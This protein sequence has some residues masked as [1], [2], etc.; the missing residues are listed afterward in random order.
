ML[1]Y[2]T[3]PILP[4]VLATQT[5]FVQVDPVIPPPRS[6][7]LGLTVSI[8][9]RHPQTVGN[10]AH[11]WRRIRFSSSSRAGTLR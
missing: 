11:S 4:P 9:S 3:P 5:P 8:L 7:N 1:T 2:I 6:G 10:A